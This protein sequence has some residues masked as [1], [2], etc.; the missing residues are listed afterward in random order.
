MELKIVASRNTVTKLMSDKLVF[1]PNSLMGKDHLPLVT[2]VEYFA[3]SLRRSPFSHSFNNLDKT[4]FGRMSKKRS[5][6]GAN[7]LTVSQEKQV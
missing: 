1:L 6:D 4:R 7:G 2:L 3:R 5:G